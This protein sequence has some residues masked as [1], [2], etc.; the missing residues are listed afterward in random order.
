MTFV[1]T[2]PHATLGKKLI[3]CCCKE[4]PGSHMPFASSSRFTN[5]NVGHALPIPMKE[6]VTQKC[7]HAPS[8][9]PRTML[10]RTFDFS[11]NGHE[12]T[13]LP[14]LAISP[15]HELISTFLRHNPGAL[16]SDRTAYLSCSCVPSPGQVSCIIIL[17]PP[18]P[19]QSY[20]QS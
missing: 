16:A 17:P 13:L 15:V 8:R 7:R 12:R 10:A 11:T 2:S 6:G 4:A 20:P 14:Q 19:L 9:L 3:S 1:Y 18:I 5:I